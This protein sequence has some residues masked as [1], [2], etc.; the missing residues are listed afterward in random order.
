MTAM[1]SPRGPH[2]KKVKR[3]VPT[4]IPNRL[5]NCSPETSPELGLP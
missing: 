2:M 5:D 3:R 1:L 4:S